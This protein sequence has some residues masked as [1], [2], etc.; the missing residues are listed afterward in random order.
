[1]GVFVLHSL[2]IELYDIGVMCIKAKFYECL[3]LYSP[4]Y[5]VQLLCFRQ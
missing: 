3:I 2:T 4:A 1:V 5:I